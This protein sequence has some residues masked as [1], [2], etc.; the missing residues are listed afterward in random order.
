MLERLAG[1]E[2]N[3][4]LIQRFWLV[5]WTVVHANTSID[6]GAAGSLGNGIESYG[7]LLSAA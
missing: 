4:G 1:K 3:E 6:A 5:A 2:V 7:L